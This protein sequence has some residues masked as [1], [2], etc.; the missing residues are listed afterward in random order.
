MFVAKRV[1]EIQYLI[2]RSCGNHVQSGDIAADLVSR[3][4]LG[5]VHTESN[6]P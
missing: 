5:Q 4:V 3:G 6:K 2:P 1:T